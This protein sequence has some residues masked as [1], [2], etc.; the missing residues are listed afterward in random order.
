MAKK[1]YYWVG[2]GVLS[3]GKDKPSVEYGD[4]I[5]ASLGDDALN[6][7]LAKGKIAE[8]LPKPS[9]ASQS[10][11]EKQVDALKEKLAELTEEND[12]L[13]E[14]LAAIDDIVDPKE[15]ADAVTR[16]EAAEKQVVELTEQL[17]G[18]KK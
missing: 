2:E 9:G 6:S 14:K 7:L 10:D 11:A 8:K 13:K 4:K 3:Q 16:A 12:A 18:G 17:T 5:P 15:L 1:T